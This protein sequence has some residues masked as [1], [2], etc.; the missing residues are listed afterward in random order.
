MANKIR[1]DLHCWLFQQP[2]FAGTNTAN[3]GGG[4]YFLADNFAALSSAFTQII[5]EIQ[6]VNTTFTAPAVSVNAFNRV[7]N[8]KELFFTLFKPEASPV[9]TGNLKRYELDFLLDSNG[10]PID[11]NNDGV[12]DDPQVLDDRSP[13]QLAVD[14]QTGFFDSASAQLLDVGYRCP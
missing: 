7:T 8:R 5:T 13:Q 1:C 11:T 3:K 14:P 12:P 6:A 9:W 2:N 4:S 10:D